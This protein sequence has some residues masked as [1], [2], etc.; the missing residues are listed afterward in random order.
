MGTDDQKL[1][2]WA[3]KNKNESRYNGNDKQITDEGAR[4]LAACVF[5]IEIQLSNTQVTDV[6]VEVL[7][8]TCSI[9]NHINLNDCTQVT[10]TGVLALARCEHLEKIE[11][12]NTQVGD[13]GVRALADWCDGLKHID[14]SGTKVTVKAKQL[15]KLRLKKLTFHVGPLV[16][17]CLRAPPNPVFASS[18]S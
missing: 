4:A 12:R 18:L 7:A 17:P 1:I 9:L 13:T 11:L 2:A 6:G 3:G 16:L 14:L 15:M 10:D 5:L 8:R